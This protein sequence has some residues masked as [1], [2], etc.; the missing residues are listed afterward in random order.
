MIKGLP[1]VL[2]FFRND[3]PFFV[4]VFVNDKTVF[5][6]HFEDLERFDYP[7]YE[8]SDELLL[9]VETRLLKITLVP[10][11]FTRL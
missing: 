2:Y 9:N 8:V 7:G 1:G 3:R 10:I 4:K 6:G 11:D 5:E